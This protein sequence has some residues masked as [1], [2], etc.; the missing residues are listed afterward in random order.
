MRHNEFQL[1]LQQC[2]RYIPDVQRDALSRCKRVENF[3]GNLDQHFATDK[4][5]TLLARLVYSTQDERSGV[6][7]RHSIPISTGANIRAG[8]SSLASA[9]RLYREFSDA[10]PS[11]TQLIRPVAVEITK[12]PAITP[13]QGAPMSQR[14]SAPAAWPEW[15]QPSKGDLLQLARITIPFIRFLH[16]DIVRAIVEDNEQHHDDWQTR[17]Q[18]RGIDPALYLWERSTCTFPGVRRYA[19]STEIAQHRGRMETTRGPEGALKLDDNHYPKIV[20]SFVFR[21]K[22]FQNMGPSGYSLAHLADHKQYKNRDTR[23]ST[24]RTA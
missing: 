22:T 2:T 12:Q 18:E 20:W 10:W 9:I 3:E 23:S 14:A 1:W 21:G 5:A 16:P 8:T 24:L 17:L 13:L 4:M 11:G 7:P 19:G 15:G 6:V